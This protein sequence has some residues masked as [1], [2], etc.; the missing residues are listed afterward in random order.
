MKKPELLLPVG[1]TEAFYAAVEGG[2]DAIYLGLR[3]FNARNRAK[4]FT[5]NQLQS[6]LAE[7]KRSNTKV[8]L[9]LNTLIKNSELPELLDVLYQISQT[10]LSSIIIQDWGVYYLARKFFPNIIL[11]ASTQMAF[12]NSIGAEFAKRK[13]FE[14]VI[15]ARELTLEELRTISKKSKIELEIFSHGALCYSF[16]GVC[17]FSS[18]LGGMSANRGQCRQPCR[19]TFK[20]GEKEDYF[21]SLKDNQQ[22][23]IVP[24]LMKLGISSL[25][26][27]G[28]M[29]SAE[30]VNRVA[31]AYRMVIDNPNEMQQA[32]Q[33][34][35]Y[36]MGR[37]K[38]SYFL[39]GNVSNA[40]TKNPFVGIHIGEV[41]KTK[42]TKFSFTTSEDLKQ[43]YRIRIQPQN[44]MDSKAIKLKKEYGFNE[45]E[46]GGTV[47][48]NFT[49]ESFS[50]GDKVFLIGAP[51]EKFRT[52]FQLDGKKIN[53]SLP[54]KKKQNILGKIGSGKQ[55]HHD[56]LFV[57]INSLRWLR[58]LYLD[59]FDHLILHLT[60]NEW[61]QLNLQSPFMKK[62]IHKFIVELPKFIPEDDVSYY[63]DLCLN[64]SRQGIKNFMIS[65][66][67]QKLLLP[68]GFRA[69]VN[70]NV[71]AL[72]DAAIQFLKED[73]SAL[74]I[75]PYEFDYENLINGK[76]RNGIVPLYF[77]PELFHS[78]MPVKM[79]KPDSDG[80]SHFKDR[81]HLY[82]KIVRDGV[83]IVI[84][85]LP[86]SLF[87]YKDNIHK[88]GFRRFLI[89]LSHV[90]P[91]Q[92]TFNRLQKRYKYSEAEQ[93]GYA[94]NFKLGLS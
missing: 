85:E 15:M 54:N 41:T 93:P 27:E 68:I 56:E 73:N 26:V 35:S 86:V 8:Y 47:N 40:I 58:K 55:L 50:K 31:K 3:Y 72:N 24:E 90:K 49:Q 37:E 51:T 78:R 46:S 12:H 25:K 77:Y 7:S 81:D 28:R 62:N 16:S 63:R 44:G 94:F 74:Y 29:K 52:K 34:L 43:N 57:R 71:Y 21:F 84:P 32:K 87:Q 33:L 61:S 5:L 53:L 65:H 83:T 38:T 82:R 89:D 66:I 2:A 59:K 88:N 60:K 64:F 20:S 39:G 36:D 23:E 79:D 75:Y 22:I 18:F 80:Y 14:R 76:D 48:L 6:I 70:E 17:L 92:N 4:N 69:S 11:H 91:S 30:Y 19:R 9:T 42:G 13:N 10:S 67:S 45:V 1:N